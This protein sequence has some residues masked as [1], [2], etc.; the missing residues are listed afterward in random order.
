MMGPASNLDLPRPTEIAQWLVAKH[1]KPGNLAIDATAGNGH[2]TVLLAR[3]VG[4]EGQVIAFDVQQAAIDATRDRLQEQ[5][6][7]PQ[8]SLYQCCHSEMEKLIAPSSA[9][10]VMFNLGYLP[11][12]DH[13]MTTE[14][15]VTRRALHAAALILQ[16]GGLLSVVAY[17]GH[18]EGQREAASVTELIM[19]LAEN[20]WRVARYEL[21]G[22]RRAA[23]FLL[24]ATKPA[25]RS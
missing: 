2:D 14:T 7:L 20:G 11:G 6:L 9:A 19:G 21:C 22:T 18:D 15:D 12:G 4:C 10:V 1:L 23:P 3:A 5:G 25:A 17:P 8:V 13:Q 16:A 24:A